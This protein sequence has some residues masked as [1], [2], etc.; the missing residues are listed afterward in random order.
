MN[1]HEGHDHPDLEVVLQR[2]L[3]GEY[4][5]LAVE[6]VG[7]NQEAIDIFNADID[8]KCVITSMMEVGLIPFSVDIQRQVICYISLALAV[9]KRIAEGRC[10]NP[11]A[12][13][14]DYNVGEPTPIPDIFKAALEDLD[15]ESI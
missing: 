4:R 15:T 13:V 7:L 14:R 11:E 6:A 10:F 1:G 5:A 2:M 12:A 9:Q 8:L 3:T